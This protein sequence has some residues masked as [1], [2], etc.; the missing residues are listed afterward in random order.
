MPG[1]SCDFKATC[2]IF[3]HCNFS[4]DFEDC[5]GLPCQIHFLLRVRSANEH[6][7]SSESD[8]RDWPLEIP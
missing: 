2:G 7:I 3:D 6:Q 8:Q 5:I 4:K 1:S